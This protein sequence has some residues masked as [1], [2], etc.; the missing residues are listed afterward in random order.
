MKPYYDEGGIRIFHADCRQIL[1][2]VPAP[3]LVL[4][5]PPYGIGE[6]GGACRTRGAP[7]YS[8]HE[9]LGWDNERPARETFAAIRPRRVEKIKYRKFGR[10]FSPYPLAA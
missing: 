9:N 7:G 5:D 3:D 8:K 4:T 6:H 1:W 10:F 2:A